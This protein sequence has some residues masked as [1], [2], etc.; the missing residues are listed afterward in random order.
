MT[1]AYLREAQAT[2]EQ[3]LVEGH[4]LRRVVK[5]MIEARAENERLMLLLAAVIWWGGR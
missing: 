1:E 3:L 4:P 5:E 2:L